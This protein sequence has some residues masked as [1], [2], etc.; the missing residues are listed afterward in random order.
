MIQPARHSSKAVLSVDLVINAK[1][2]PSIIKPTVTLNGV[3]LQDTTRCDHFSLAIK[4]AR[5]GPSDG[6]ID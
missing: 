1:F 4:L 6:I 3:L 2:S 5:G